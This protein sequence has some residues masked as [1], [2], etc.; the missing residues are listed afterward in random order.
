MRWNKTHGLLGAFILFHLTAGAAPPGA[1][2]RRIAVDQ[3]GYMPEMTKVAVISDPQT[4]FNATESFT[5]A[6]TVQVRRW[7]DHVVVHSGAPTA[8][9]NGSTH[10]QSGDRVWWFDFTPVT[11]WGEYYIY[12]PVADVRSARFRIEHDVYDEVLRHAAR[13]FYYQRRGTAKITPFADSRWTDTTNFMD[14]LQD[15]QARLISNPV[16]GTQKDLRGGWFDAGDYN[17]YVNFTDSVM[18][19]LLMA[20]LR[21]PNIWP[22]DWDIPE[23]GNGIPDLLDEIKWELD[24][25][26]RMQNSNGS[27][28]SKMGVN[29]FQSASPPS[30]EKSQV[31]YGAESTTATLSAAATFAQ[32]ATIFRVMGQTNYS[33]TLSN[34]AIAAY[35]WAVANPAVMFSNTGFSS[36]NPEVGAGNYNAERDKFR[37]RAAVYLYDLTRQSSYRTFVEANYANMRP[38]SSWW[39]NPYDSPIQD[40]LLHYTTLP[41]ISVTASN[42]IMERKH[43]S[44]NGRDF[45]GAWNSRTDAYRS[46]M[47]DATYHWGSS[48]MKCRVAILFDQHAFYR[49]NSTQNATYRSAAAGFLHYIHGVNPLTMVY[50]SNMYDH[51]GDYC[52]NTFYHS[53]FADGTVYDDALTSPVGPPPG[54]LVG[55]PNKDFSPDAAYNGP[56]LAPP[57]DQPPQKAYRDWN[58][59]WPENSWEISEPAI[60]YQSAYLALLSARMRPL[61]YSDWTLGHALTGTNAAPEADLDQDGLS[62]VAEY[63]FGL[64]PRTVD[65]GLAP[66]FALK[67]H[68]NGP[69]SG[70]YLTMDLPRRMGATNIGVTVQSSTNLLLWEPLAVISGTNSPSGPGVVREQGTGHTRTVTVR[71]TVPVE[72]STTPRFV[73]VTFSSN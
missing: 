22:D 14:A 54:Y 17:E 50:L 72:A 42:T 58:T 51:G 26:L 31:F 35:N 61:T 68:T 49:I 53:W 63:L 16:A 69:V 47:S 8:W 33:L 46:Y 37:V 20:Y 1:F 19:D 18:S 41:G 36:A 60:Y 40:A 34:A 11:A 64:S 71:D 3:F 59:S 65:R 12:D 55:G 4:G 48:Q 39:W 62:N 7:S 5:P 13:V 67:S 70:T 9:N 2:S 56:R 28:L 27:V 57:L 21:N 52:V 73:R 15:T 6:A 43:S 10:A 45:L 32:A 38:V 30:A 66:Q 23:S 24:W 44:M 25:L 29:G